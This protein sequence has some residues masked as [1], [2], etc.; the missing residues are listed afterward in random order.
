MEC[1]F[2]KSV[3]GK[4]EAMSKISLQ[5]TG[6]AGIVSC[7]EIRMVS[8]G[9]TYVI[10]DVYVCGILYIPYGRINGSNDV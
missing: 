5:E 8:D 10:T 9:V 1:S 4:L 2:V 6:K 7:F 3:E